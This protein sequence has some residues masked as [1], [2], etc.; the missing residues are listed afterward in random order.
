MKIK[1]ILLF[2]LF[3]GCISPID[4]IDSPTLPERGFYMGMNLANP[5]Q[6]QEFKDPYMI[7]AEYAEFVTIWSVGVG[8]EGFW[9][10]A[11]KLKELGI[12]VVLIAEYLESSPLAKT[13]WI[14]AIAA[15]YN[16]EQQAEKLF[17]EIDNNYTNYL[18]LA[19]TFRQ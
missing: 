10:Y 11:E 19:E 9:E 13:E 1:K 6:G 12:Q 8:A 18:N 14:K 4:P 15:F 3:V 17:N 7:T 2:T 16:K 5:I